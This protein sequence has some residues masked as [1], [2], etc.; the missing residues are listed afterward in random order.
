MKEVGLGWVLDNGENLAGQRGDDLS[1]SPLPKV[2]L[3]LQ[4]PYAILTPFL[5]LFH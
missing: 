2:S 1:R 3:I 5:H 4:E